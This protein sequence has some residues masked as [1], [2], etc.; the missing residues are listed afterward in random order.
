LQNFHVK[1]AAV[2]SST[3]VLFGGHR[4]YL[5]GPRSIALP[6]KHEFTL[7]QVHFAHKTLDLE[8]L[9]GSKS[10]SSLLRLLVVLDEAATAWTLL[11]VVAHLETILVESKLEEAHLLDTQETQTTHFVV[12]PLFKTRF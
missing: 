2:L 9:G 10:S 5:Q 11:E 12:C 4:R 6:T 3:R 1:T 8:L 7:L